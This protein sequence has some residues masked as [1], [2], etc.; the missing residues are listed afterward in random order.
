MRKARVIYGG[1][2]ALIEIS[3][4]STSGRVKGI[5]RFPYMTLDKSLFNLYQILNCAMFKYMI[6]YACPLLKIPAYKIFFMTHC[7]F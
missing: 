5:S 4:H 3:L 6:L 1:Q 2:V 7:Y